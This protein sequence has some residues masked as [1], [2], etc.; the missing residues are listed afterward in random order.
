MFNINH[1]ISFYQ[2]KNVWNF[3]QIYLFTTIA[4]LNDDLFLWDSR[5]N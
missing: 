1:S 4:S 3:Y 2:E 5:Y